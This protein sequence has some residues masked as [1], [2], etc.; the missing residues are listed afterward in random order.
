MLTPHITTIY[1]LEQ[2]EVQICAIDFCNKIIMVRRVPFAVTTAIDDTGSLKLRKYGAHQG[3][4]SYTEKQTFSTIYHVFLKAFA[5]LDKAC[6]Y[7]PRG[8]IT[9]F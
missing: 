8:Q 6:R 1:G 7:L 9:N 5:L 4:H 3:V 2:P